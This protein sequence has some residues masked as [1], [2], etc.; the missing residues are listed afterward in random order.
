MTIPNNVVNK[1]I[2][3][4][5]E[6][7]SDRVNFEK[8]IIILNN[9][10][11]IIEILI[12]NI[13]IKF[14]INQYYPFKKPYKI[15]INN[16]LYIDILTNLHCDIIK[17]MYH[18]KC[19]CCESIL[20]TWGPTL[21]LENLIEEILKNIGYINSYYHKQSF[22]LLSANGGRYSESPFL[23]DDICRLISTYLIYPTTSIT[24]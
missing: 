21:K 6:Q 1:R 3:K 2:T 5:L 18:K 8:N 15:T 19:L 11:Y 10:E 22:R 16:R 12:Y 24:L 4:E 23:P 14:Y 17:K 7:I 13:N 20:C 9:K